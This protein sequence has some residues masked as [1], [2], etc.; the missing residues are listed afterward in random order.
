M[1]KSNE[2]LGDSGNPDRSARLDSLMNAMVDAFILINEIGTIERFNVAAET[3]F[4][5]S[6][7]DVLGENIRILMSGDDKR[8]HDSYLNRYMGKRKSKVIGIGREVLARRKDG[9]VFP[10]DVAL[11]EIGVEG[12]LRFIG[13]VRDLTKQREAEQ[14][15]LRQREEMVNTS[16]LTIM[17]EMA[18]AMAHELNQPLSAISNY[19]SA[20][21][22][23]LPDSGENIEDLRDL[24]EKI[25]TQ[26][27]RAGEVIRRTRDFTRSADMKR[28]RIQPAEFLKEIWALAELDSKAN[29]IAVS[30]DI[31]PDLPEVIVDSLQ[32][33]Q[34]ILNLLR[35]GVDAMAD[36]PPENRQL[37]LSAFSDNPDIVTITVTDQGG[38]ITPEVSA[39]LFHP[40]F[41]TKTSGMGMGL[42]IS[43]SIAENHGGT[44]KF[45][46][47]EEDGVSF[48]LTIPTRVKR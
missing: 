10:A 19:A 20:G 40:F 16:R 5:Y 46:N 47:N 6:A 24:L 11:G 1:S 25:V 48:I 41:T 34:V 35:N 42:A 14:H 18:A 44:L 22:R 13:I 33:Q 30:F 2:T 7:D 27:H 28:K 12:S 32:I 43:R 23:L 26:A 45:T 15:A 29:N 3:M 21:I 17:G 37:V 39:K 9:S 31:Q 36:T 4:G 38:G 8:N